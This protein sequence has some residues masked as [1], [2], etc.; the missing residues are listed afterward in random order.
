MTVTIKFEHYWTTE[1]L[2]EYLLIA[3]NHMHADLYVPDGAGRW[4]L[5]SASKPEDT[6]ELTSCDCRLKMADLY[7]KIEFS[8]VTLIRP[9]ES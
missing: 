2:K 5:T 3:S 9:L 8:Q 4:I 1:S 7:E 6:I